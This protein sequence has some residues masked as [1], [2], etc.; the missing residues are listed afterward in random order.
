MAQVFVSDVRERA[1]VRRAAD[2]KLGWRHEQRRDDAAA[3]EQDAHGQRSRC[4]QLLRVADPS[5]WVVRR[6][7]RIAFDERHHAHTGFEA[8]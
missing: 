4:E 3:D 5:G 1:A 7:V 6:V 8:G 2:L